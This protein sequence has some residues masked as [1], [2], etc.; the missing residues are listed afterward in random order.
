MPV[1]QRTL[2][3]RTPTPNMYWL[4]DVVFCRVCGTQSKAQDVDHRPSSMKCVLGE[5]DVTESCQVQTCPL[6]A[7]QFTVVRCLAQLCLRLGV[8]CK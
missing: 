3:R 2:I 7:V 1:N 8:D 5:E 6:Y 4:C